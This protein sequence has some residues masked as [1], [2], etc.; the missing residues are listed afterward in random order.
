MSKLLNKIDA[1]KDTDYCSTE[2]KIADL[3]SLKMFIDSHIHCNLM[4]FR[5]LMTSRFGILEL[6]TNQKDIRERVMKI[7]LKLSENMILDSK[8]KFT[9]SVGTELRGP[10]V[11]S[12]LFKLVVL[13][14]VVFDW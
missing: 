13:S 2:I 7:L 10:M 5:H 8:K 1:W 3:D 4:L 14:K 11:S 12:K 9:P 6:L